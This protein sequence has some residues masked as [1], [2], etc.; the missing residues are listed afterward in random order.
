MPSY[1]LS[2]LHFFVHDMSSA[3]KLSPL[4]NTH[5]LGVSLRLTSYRQM[6]AIPTVG[7]HCP[8]YTPPMV[9]LA[10]HPVIIPLSVHQLPRERWDE[11][12]HLPFTSVTHAIGH[13]MGE[14]L[15]ELLNS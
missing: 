11:P 9:H 14:D 6:Q 15:Y 5:F 1:A 12:F 4:P 7:S 13:R 2:C 10:A 3:I 8:V